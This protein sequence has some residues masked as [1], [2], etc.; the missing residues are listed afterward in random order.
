MTSCRSSQ[1]GATDTHRA[2]DFGSLGLDVTGLRGA[3]R[4][5]RH[6]VCAGA[7]SMPLPPRPCRG[8]GQLTGRGADN[9]IAPLD[10]KNPD[11]D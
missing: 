3:Y 9:D 6:R 4:D 1:N 11:L 8:I 10:E 2:R 7:A 5:M